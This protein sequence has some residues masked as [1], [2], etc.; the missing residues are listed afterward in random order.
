MS[1]FEKQEQK[2]LRVETRKRDAQAGKPVPH[3]LKEAI[4]NLSKL[5]ETSTFFLDGKTLDVYTKVLDLA[6]NYLTAEKRIEAY[7]QTVS[8]AM[9][10]LAVDQ[11]GTSAELK[12]T[13]HNIN[14]DLQAR[15]TLRAKEEET[16]DNLN[17]YLK[18]WR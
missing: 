13:L 1:E 11:A 16:L 4:T 18:D 6:N 3:G 8:E 7:T 5:R 12:K 15:A 2:R 17:Q 14:V 10:Q 9:N